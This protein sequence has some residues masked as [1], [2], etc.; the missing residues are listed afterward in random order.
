VLE[1]RDVDAIGFVR[2][3]RELSDLKD[4]IDATLD[5]RD[6]NQ[7]LGHD[8]TTAEVIAQISLRLVQNPLARNRRGA[9]QR[10]AA[11]MG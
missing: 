6:L 7:A 10:D 11:H 9:C 5:H 3:Y 4:F 2:D 1:K 8:R